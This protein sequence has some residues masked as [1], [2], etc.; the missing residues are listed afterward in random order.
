MEEVFYKIPLYATAT[1]GSLGLLYLS[2]YLI[3]R[4]INKILAF[5]NFGRVLIEWNRYGGRC[6]ECRQDVYTP[7][8]NKELK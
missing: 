7:T 6:K 4:T 8:I 5:R 2:T 1:A 3:E